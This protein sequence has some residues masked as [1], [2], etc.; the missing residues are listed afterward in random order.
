MKPLHATM[1]RIT[2]RRPRATEP[3]APWLGSAR[4]AG[5]LAALLFHGSGAE[6]AGQD[7]SVAIS[8]P[9]GPGGTEVVVRARGLPPG[10]TVVVGFGGIAS[11]HEILGEA[12]TD[13]EGALSL[14]D[15]IPSWVEP[16][17][18]YLFYV[19]FSDQ[20]PVAFSDPFLVTGP[21]GVVR[22]R[23]RI[24]DEGV[25]CPAMRGPGEELY[26]LAGS[27]GSAVP[28]DDVAVTAT[29]ADASI[30]MQGITLVVQEIEG[31]T[32]RG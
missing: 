7:V 4:R 14:T 13:S 3:R 2:T 19:A 11:P 22:V 6:A 23:G 8:P 30:C 10:S 26:T 5:L 16:N 20:R 27:L 17:R 28:G 15:T 29:I 18:S 31:A 12:P 1:S 32:P 9:G 25:T 24:T 21:D